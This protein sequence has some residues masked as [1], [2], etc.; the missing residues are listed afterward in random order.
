M[1]ISCADARSGLVE[2]C[3]EA[4]SALRPLNSVRRTQRI[5][6]QGVH[7]DWEHW[8]CLFPQHGPDRKHKRRIELAP[9]QTRVVDAR[10]EEFVRG[11]FHSDG[12]RTANR[13]KRACAGGTMWY[14]YPRYF[15]SNESADI[16]RV[17]GHHLDRLGVEWRTARRNSLFVARKEAVARLDGFVGPKR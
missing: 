17:L 15:F 10:T 13:V 11:L 3:V 12:C 6:C 5:G 9:W 4:I 14:E 2:E 1:R 8:P 7:A 16:Q